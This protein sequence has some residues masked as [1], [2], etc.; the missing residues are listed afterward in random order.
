MVD[1]PVNKTDGTIPRLS[2]TFPFLSRTGFVIWLCTCLF[3]FDTSLLSYPSITSPLTSAT[4][5]GI[6]LSPSV[7]SVV[8]STTG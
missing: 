8:S 5:S 7:P 1:N 4:L 2:G 3:Q 6:S